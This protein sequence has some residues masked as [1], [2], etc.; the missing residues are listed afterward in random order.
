MNT[1]LKARIASL[2]STVDQLEAE[3]VYL[4]EILIRCGFPEGITTL[5]GT[6]EEIL[7]Q[8]VQNIYQ[9][10]STQ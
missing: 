9:R 6:V 8:D 7:S 3:L 4:N 10:K 1:D 5:K 2:E